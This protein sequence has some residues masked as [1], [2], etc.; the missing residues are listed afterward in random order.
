MKITRYLSATATL[1]LVGAIMP[2]SALAQTAAPA[3]EASETIIVTGSRIPRPN[4]DTSA[5]IVSVPATQLTSTGDLS[6]GD[7]LNRL[8]ALRS[9]FSQANSTS[10]IGT[11]GLNLLDL[12]GLGTNRT[13][14]LVNGRRHI[15]A[16]PGQFRVDTNTIPSDLVERI[17][18]VTG[19]TSSIYGSDAVSGVV[20]F[21]LKKDFTGLSVRAQ[22]GVSTRGD[23]G[24]RFLSAVW[25]TNFMDDR[26]NIAIGVEYANQ[27]TLLFQDRPEQTGAFSGVP[28]YFQVDN[29]LG[30]PPEGD[31][32]PDT[33][34]FG[35]NP[36][37]T[38]G[39][40]SLGG[41]VNTVCPALTG[42]PANLAQRAA[43]CTGELSPTGGRLARNWVFLNDGSLVRDTPALDL[44]S[45]GGG[46]FGG[47]TASGVEGAMLLP[48][49]E[50]INANLLFNMKI[51]PAFEPFLEAKYV[52]ITNNQT[53][54]QPTFINSTLSPVFQLS[55]PYLS[56]AA[57]SQ[58]S[59]LTGGASTFTMFRFNND[60]GT[61][62]EDH[63][64]DTFRIVGG[65]RGTLWDAGNLTYEVSLNYG[66]VDTFY[67]TGG[68]VNV[69]KFNNAANAVLSN[70]QIVCGINADAI[71]TNDDAACRPINL[72]GQNAP[73]TTP[74]GLAYVLYESSRK[75]WA[76]QLQAQAF[77]AGDT[78][79]FLNLPGGPVG[80]SVGAEYRREDAYS[81]YDPVTASGATFLNS[82]LDFNPPAV[83]VKE[84]FGEIRIPL[85]RDIPFFHELTVEGS[86][87]YAKYNFL[88]KGVT[89]WNAGIV[90]AP[91]PDIRFRATL[92]RSVRTPNL[93]DLY[94]TASQGFANNFVDPCSQ[95]VINQDPNR[96][97]NCAAAGIPTTI[98]LPDGS[99]VPWVNTLPSGLSGTSSGN[100]N[101]NPEVGK[102]FTLGAVF[103][104]RF[105]PGFSLTVDYYNIE[106]RQAINSLTGQQVINRCYDDPVSI[107]N[108]FCAAVFR[109]FSA[110]DPILNGTFAGQSG[111]RFAGFTDFTLPVT[112][113]GYISA[114]FNFA[115]LKT[116][117]IDFDM[118]YRHNYSDNVKLSLS[119]LVSWLNKREQFTFITD[120]ARSVRVAGVLGDPEIQG[121]FSANLDVGKFDLNYDMRYVGRQ[122]L[123]A[124]ETMFSHQGRPP[125][126][127]DLRP[128]PYVP[129]VIYHDIQVGVKVTDKARFF[130]GMDNI[131]DQLPPL[132]LTGTGD[133]SGI[134]PVQGRYVYGGLTFKM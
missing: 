96:A 83:N 78:G 29:T 124:Y 27:N 53:S 77:V 120:P 85:L 65:A 9:T 55:N 89:A 68:N 113:P 25:G 93:S 72:F 52:K 104:P 82:F 81:A 87:R 131:F 10:A 100:P 62:S 128:D 106:I 126:N 95:T 41:T 105:L 127:A 17:E 103:Q 49:L 42:T 2:Q 47:L 44:R 28:G 88:T 8:P 79:A 111:R 7:Q 18:V 110:T 119:V 22:G 63:K 75:Q 76:E 121:Q 34:F 30:E 74:A 70:G 5:P 32:I 61:R 19:G 66:R 24:S 86:G 64:R 31:G 112:G 1:A 71:T 108:P 33:A 60:I 38:F 54:T 26:A 37:N 56:A 46:I 11:A 97:R 132:G 58:I 20:N 48:G 116:S 123:D 57:R 80:F 99:V 16:T 51:S 98:T 122:I 130:L 69:A 67:K 15:T 4:I 6:L 118:K 43:N 21:V 109:R 92:S 134:F 101:L 102:S 84:I 125:T 14:V 45:V 13:L 12:R 114:P 39:I 117:G 107:V 50:R 73:L 23:R 91:I 94:A 59:V 129:R 133:G 115:K 3:E 35:T 40:I 36:G 90:W